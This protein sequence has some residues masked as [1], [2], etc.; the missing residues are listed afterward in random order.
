MKVL[1]RILA[2]ALLTSLVAVIAPAQSKTGLL[3][4]EEAKKAAPKDYYFRGQSAPVQTRNTAGIRATADGKLVLAGLVDT[5]G[6]A[7]DVQAKYLGLFITEVK[8]V[9]GGQSL[10]PGQYGF[11]FTKDGKFILSDVGANDLVSVPAGND[12]AMKRPVPLQIT[13]DGGGFRLYA[14]KHYVGITLQ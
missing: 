3:S 2:A 4:A 12:D 11:G 10:A 8:V 1:H 7:A 9:V 14:G 5:S 13:A 6:Y